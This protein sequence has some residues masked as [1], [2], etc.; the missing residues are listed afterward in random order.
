MGRY[1]EGL[2]ERIP[3]GGK[4]Y[5]FGEYMPYTPSRLPPVEQTCNS[6]GETLAI[7]MVNYG[8][9]KICTNCRRRIHRKTPTAER[10]HPFPHNHTGRFGTP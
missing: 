4:A 9:G 6:C 5:D 10:G 8:S 3:R 7:T 2:I 1:F